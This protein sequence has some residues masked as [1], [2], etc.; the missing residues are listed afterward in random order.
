[1]NNKLPVG[2]QVSAPELLC[3]ISCTTH[4]E[5]MQ[6]YTLLHVYE[7][8]G[9]KEWVCASD[10]N[11]LSLSLSKV[12]FIRHTLLT[13]RRVVKHVVTCGWYWSSTDLDIPFKKDRI[14]ILESPWPHMVC[15]TVRRNNPGESFT[16]VEQVGDDNFH[17]EECRDEDN[18]G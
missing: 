14:D 1:M 17:K 18:L 4:P 10:P 2:S 15:S 7:I 16:Q 5:W 9:I 11:T 8:H 13:S 3:F 12:Y 6:E